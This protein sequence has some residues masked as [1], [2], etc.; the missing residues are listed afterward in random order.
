MRGI[1][2]TSY[3]SGFRPTMTAEEVMLD[4]GLNLIHP[5]GNKEE[6]YEMV[7]QASNRL[8]LTYFSAKRLAVALGQ[9]IR[10]YEQQFGPVELN[11]AKRRTDQP[12]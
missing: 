4:F 11:A 3:V 9:I 1:S 2:Q 12:M 7:F 10:R 8:I 5:T 6:P